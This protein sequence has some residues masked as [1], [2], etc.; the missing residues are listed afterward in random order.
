MYST[1]VSGKICKPQ[2]GE[3]CT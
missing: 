2:R 3:F 1:M